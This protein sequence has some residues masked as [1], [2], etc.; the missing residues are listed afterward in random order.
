MLCFLKG[1]YLDW[2]WGHFVEEEL[3]ERVD[4]AFLGEKKGSANGF[5]KV[6]LY[7]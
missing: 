7:Y 6:S 1:F 3:K 2:D 5:F 4:P